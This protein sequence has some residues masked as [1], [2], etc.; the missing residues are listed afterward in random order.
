M[1]EEFHDGLHEWINQTA[2]KLTPGQA[3]LGD[4]VGWHIDYFVLKSGANTFPEFI[5]S[6]SVLKQLKPKF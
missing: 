3:K 6:L 1:A 4:S 5:K 2:H